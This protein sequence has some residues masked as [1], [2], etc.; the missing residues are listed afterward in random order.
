MNGQIKPEDMGGAGSAEGDNRKKNTRATL[1]EERKRHISKYRATNTRCLYEFFTAAAAYCA[2]LSLH[3]PQFCGLTFWIVAPLVHMRLFIMFHDCGHNSFAPS[4]RANKILHRVLSVLVMTPTM[5]RE[6]HR[7]HHQHIGKVDN[8]IDFQWG[9]SVYW[10]KQELDQ[11]RPMILRRFLQ[12]IRYPPIYFPVA[13]FYEWNIR[14]RMPVL[15]PASGYTTLDNLINT[16]AVLAYAAVITWLK[17]SLFIKDMFISGVVAQVVGL[18]LFHTQHS[19]ENGYRVTSKEWDPVDAAIQGSSCTVFPEFAQ[20][21]MMGIGYHHIHHFD[22]R[23]PGYLLRECYEQGDPKLWKG[24]TV[25]DMSDLW[26]AMWTTVWDE[27]Q[28]KYV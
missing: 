21:S 10:T 5:W 25:L 7:R 3:G 11:L 20:W 6:S 8:E 26:K 24:V 16:T 18:M 17:G 2:L 12:L 9:D 13:G 22:S 27:E 14:H 4:V 19:F 23:V 1:N 15:D 28:K